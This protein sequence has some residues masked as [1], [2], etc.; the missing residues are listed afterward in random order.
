MP[1]RREPCTT[2]FRFG[3][4]QSWLAP[5]L[6]ES[7]AHQ[8]SCQLRLEKTDWASPGLGRATLTKSVLKD[9]GRIPDVG[10]CESVC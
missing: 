6:G 3:E 7:W 10:R 9:T 8:P 2:F 4:D 5:A 1:P